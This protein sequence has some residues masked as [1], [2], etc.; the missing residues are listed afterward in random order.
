MALL[1]LCPILNNSRNQLP[2][3]TTPP[4]IK[5]I[6]LISLVLVSLSSELPARNFHY[7]QPAANTSKSSLFNIESLTFTLELRGRMHIRYE[8]KFDDEE[9]DAPAISIP[10]A[11]IA[12]KPEISKFLAS[13]IEIDFSKQQPELRDAYIRIKPYR[14]FRLFAGYSKKP[15][16]YEEMTSYFRLPFTSR[17]EAN[18]EFGDALLIGRD[19]GT[20]IYGDF[21]KKY[22]LRYYLGI[23]NGSDRISIKDDNSYKQKVLRIEQGWKN[24][25]TVGTSISKN[26]SQITGKT[27]D[28]FG[29]DALFTK[30]RVRISCEYQEGHNDKYNLSRGFYVWTEVRVFRKIYLEYR[31]E[32]FDKN[33]KKTGREEIYTYGLTL[34]PNKRNRIQVNGT[35]FKPVCREAFWEFVIQGQLEISGKLNLHLL[36]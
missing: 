20:Y 32:I 24:L 26:R 4:V 28:Y 16:S 8:Y 19:V 22:H 3:H 25:M 31:Y 30:K 36:K 12:I 35:Y 5:N 9:V 1:T 17:T 10:R 6:I 33:S 11:R 2:N 29:C 27:H 14:Y 34:S 21:G 18:D 23:F 15:L 7:I 13:E